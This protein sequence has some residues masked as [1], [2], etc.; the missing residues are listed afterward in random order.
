M[1]LRHIEDVGRHILSH[2]KPWLTGT[3]NAQAFALADGVVHQAIVPADLLIPVNIN[4]RPRLGRQVILQKRLKLPFTD[5]A[6]SCAVFFV[7][8]NQMMVNRCLPHLALGQMPYGKQGPLQLF[9]PQGIES[10]FD[11]CFDPLL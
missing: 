2:N 6:D 1:P 11:P 10:R 8:G 4:H 9:L 5:E 3:T 7:G